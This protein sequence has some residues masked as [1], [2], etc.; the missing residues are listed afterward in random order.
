MHIWLSISTLLQN[1][2]V[3]RVIGVESEGEDAIYHSPTLYDARYH[4]KPYSIVSTA[5]L[6]DNLKPGAILAVWC[7]SGDITWIVGLGAIHRP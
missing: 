7:S 2:I 5:V 4:G 3:I 1:L 6:S